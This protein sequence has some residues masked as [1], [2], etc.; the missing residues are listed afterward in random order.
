VSIDRRSISRQVADILRNMILTG[1]LPPGQ[2]VL[3]DE[4][5][6][7]LGVSTMPVREALLRL[8]HE[9]LV[10]ARHNRSFLV[11]EMTKEDLDDVYWVHGLLSGELAA[12]ACIRGGQEL[13]GRLRELVSG[14]TPAAEQDLDHPVSCYRFHDEL[15]AAATSPKLEAMLRQAT[16]FVP[17]HYFGMLAGWEESAAGAHR[18]LIAAIDA[19]DAALA[20]QVMVDHVQDAFARVAQ[21]FTSA[22]HWV[23]PDAS[24]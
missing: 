8:S 17:Q 2:P 16:R 20:T 12:R 24:S 4:M 7:R 11:T 10:E 22:G 13:A 21:H 23:E 18:R 5:S 6:T 3:H 19:A 1:E 15:N 14:S 9:G